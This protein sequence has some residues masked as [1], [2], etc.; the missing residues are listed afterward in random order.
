MFEINPSEMQG[1]A[2]MHRMY[3]ALQKYCA[4]NKSENIAFSVGFV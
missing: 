1:N 2:E 3:L 4:G